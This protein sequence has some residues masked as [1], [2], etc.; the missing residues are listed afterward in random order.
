MKSTDRSHARARHALVFAA[1][2]PSRRRIP[3][4][5]VIAAAAVSLAACSPSSDEPS[6]DVIAKDFV[7]CEMD[8][9]RTFNHRPSDL[10]DDAATSYLYACMRA[11]GYDLKVTRICTFGDTI[12]RPTMEEC[13]QSR[14]AHIEQTKRIFSKGLDAELAALDGRKPKE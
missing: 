13:Y 8:A 1:D 11:V 10:T 6:A 5:A 3:A 7:K 4:I 2:S 9:I 14:R 12:V